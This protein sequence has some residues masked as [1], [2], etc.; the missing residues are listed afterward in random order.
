VDLGLRFGLGP[1]SVAGAHANEKTVLLLGQRPTAL[2]MQLVENLVHSAL[3]GRLAKHPTLAPKLGSAATPS[4]Q[5][6]FLERADLR[7]TV[8]QA[9]VPLREVVAEYPILEVA[10]VLEDSRLAAYHQLD[11]QGQHDYCDAVGTPLQQSH[12]TGEEEHGGRGASGP[13]SVNVIP[14]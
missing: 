7:G 3:V 4:S 12:Q 5:C 10:A 8:L 13:G 2:A 9:G 11:Q 6:A 14:G 1:G